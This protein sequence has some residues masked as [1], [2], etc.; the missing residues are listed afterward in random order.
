MNKF[1][2]T[3]KNSNIKAFSETLDILEKSNTSN[4]KKY[5]I[6]INPGNHVLRLDEEN[7]ISG[8]F[9]FLN[10][11]ACLLDIVSSSILNYGFSP[12][13]E[14]F[15]INF[16]CY[17]QTEVELTIKL[18]SNKENRDYFEFEKNE[19]QVYVKNDSYTNGLVFKKRWLITNILAAIIISIIPLGLFVYMLIINLLH[20][21]SFLRGALIFIVLILIFS[22]LLF[23][24]IR[25]F[26]KRYN[27][28]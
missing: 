4:S 23:L 16:I 7:L 3:S 5:L 19:L 6:I 20:G 10:T 28:F 12:I 1:Q 2:I 27:E 15:Y 24:V 21:I 14:G 9:W 26:I 17:K 18:N 22:L 11:F 25:K 8:K 13:L